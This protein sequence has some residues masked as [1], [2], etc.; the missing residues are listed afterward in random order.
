MHLW[1]IPARCKQPRDYHFSD[2]AG[3]STIAIISY[4]GFSFWAP[5]LV[6]FW[7]G[8][9]GDEKKFA[10]KSYRRFNTSEYV[11]RGEQPLYVWKWFTSNGW[12]KVLTIAIRRAVKVMLRMNLRNNPQIQ[13]LYEYI[14]QLYRCYT[15]DGI[16]STD[17]QPM[18]QH[19][20]RYL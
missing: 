6:V 16:L 17:V 15:I 5:I 9:P 13:Q 11:F 8:V 2:I 18:L 14:L 10:I 7:G 3:R 19:L 1:R 20:Q 12:L 4:R